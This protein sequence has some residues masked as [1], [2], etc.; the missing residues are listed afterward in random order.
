MSTGWSQD[1]SGK[2][3]R[4]GWDAG[5]GA[6]GPVLDMLVERLPG[7]HHVIFSEVDGTLPQPPSRSRRSKPISPT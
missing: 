5:N 6:A 7:E 1:F 2:A 4:I 3:F